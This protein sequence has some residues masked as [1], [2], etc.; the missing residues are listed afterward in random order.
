ME[1]RRITYKLYPSKKQDEAL[2]TMC[3]A[4]RHL[5]NAALEERISAWRLASKSIGYGAQC[6]SLTQ[7][8]ANDPELRAINA[9]S[10][11]VTL[12]RLDEAFGHFFRRVREGA[13]KPGFPRF[14]SRDRFRGFGYKSHGDGFRFAPGP[15]WRNGYLRLSGIGWMQ[16]RG[17]ARTPGTVKTCSIMRKVDGWFLSLVVEC[18]PYREVD[19]DAGEI[20]GIDT[21]NEKLITTASD[22]DDVDYIPNPRLWQKAREAIIAEQKALSKEISKGKLKRRS[23]KA[24]QARK[25]LAKKHRKLSNRRRDSNHKT[26]AALVRRSRMLAR[27]EIDVAA[28]VKKTSAGDCAEAPWASAKNKF[29]TSRETLDT[30]QG[31]FF[32]MLGYKAEGLAMAGTSRSNAPGERLKSTDGIELIT[33]DTKSLKPSQRCPISWEVRK[34][35]LD[36]RIHTLPCGREIDRDHAAA[37]VMVR[38]S[39]NAEGREPAWIP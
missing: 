18:T 9:Q 24:L 39:L 4:H 13:E 5:Y 26:S 28:M 16:A 17:E 21:G 1:M 20:R 23:R 36:E 25:A 22:F 3:D 34:K 2:E 14:K 6:K 37:L 35:A 7:I 32:S 27:E 29:A 19:E 31:R 11:Q 8:R 12:K 38:A 33:L 30:S 10:L 15:G